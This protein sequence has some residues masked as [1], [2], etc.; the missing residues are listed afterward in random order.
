MV[1]EIVGRTSAI[2]VFVSKAL[3]ILAASAFLRWPKGLVCFRG[4]FTVLANGYA[5]HHE[6]TMADFKAPAIF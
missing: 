6:R 2:N 5:A 3:F 1:T 4:P